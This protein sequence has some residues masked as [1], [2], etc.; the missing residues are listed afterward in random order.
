MTLS[1]LA[2]IGETLGGLAVLVSLIYLIFEVRRNTKTA[3][4]ESAW[5]S[6]VALGELC[7]GLS[8]NPQMSELVIRAVDE[9]VRPEDLTTEEFAQYFLFCRGLLFKYEAQWYLWKE[10]TLSDEMWQNRRKW[11]KAW[12]SHPVPGRAWEIEKE[13]HQFTPGFI[14]SIESADGFGSIAIQA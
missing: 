7:E 10:G 3:R 9:G 1:E 5:N 11:A 4:S 12:V 14:E 13:Q 8:Q 6:A 2:N